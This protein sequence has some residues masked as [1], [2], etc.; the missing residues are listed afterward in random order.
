MLDRRTDYE[1][2]KWDPLEFE[3]KERGRERGRG[4]M[5]EKTDNQFFIIYLTLINPLMWTLDKSI[6]WIFCVSF[7]SILSL[8]DVNH[9]HEVCTVCTDVREEPSNMYS[10]SH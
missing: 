8:C 5:D 3:R 9:V 7:Y 10:M 4:K 6:F 2:R 1:V